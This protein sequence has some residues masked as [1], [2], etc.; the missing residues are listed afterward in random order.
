MSTKRKPGPA[1]HLGASEHYQDGPSYDRRYQA[2]TEDRDY[3]LGRTRSARTVL[4]YGAGT[5]R[6]TLALAA[7]GKHVTAVDL[8]QAM[9]DVL[10]ARLEGASEAVRQRVQVYAADMR[11]FRTRRRFDVVLV[12]FN[13]LGHLYSHDDVAG[14]LR[15]AWSHL[16]PGGRL[17]LDVVVP[18]V[19][20]PGY[21][22]IAQIQV[23][24]FEGPS[25]P[26][27]LTLRIFQPREL[28]M[29]LAR[30]GF[31][32]VRFAGDFHGAP[33]DQSSEAMVV[34]AQRPKTC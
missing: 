1:L 28:E 34:V 13:T 16:E 9:L 24:E 18:H 17:L 6:L 22:P 19:D 29:H 11:T 21:D 23:S 32:S 2:R 4:E 26:E 25:G 27:Q 31:G 12:G 14:F 3:Y 20:V 33:L 8:S 30:A 7:A 5:G 10:C 15:L